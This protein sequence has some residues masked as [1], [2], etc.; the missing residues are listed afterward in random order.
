[1]GF[2]DGY[3]TIIGA[4]GMVASGVAIIAQGMSSG[5]WSTVPEGIAAISAGLALLGVRF[6]KS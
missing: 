2:L 4:V 3:K 6:A 1:M 5:D